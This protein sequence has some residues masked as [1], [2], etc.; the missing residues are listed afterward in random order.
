MQAVLVFL[1]SLIMQFTERPK[2]GIAGFWKVSAEFLFRF[3]NQLTHK[4]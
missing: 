3:I 2:N 4:A 1:L